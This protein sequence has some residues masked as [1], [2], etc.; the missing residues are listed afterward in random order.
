[1][2]STALCIMARSQSPENSL[3][4]FRPM[5]K[6]LKKERPNVRRKKEKLKQWHVVRENVVEAALVGT[7]YVCA[8]CSMLFEKE[9]MHVHHIARR[10]TRPDLFLEKSNLLA[11]CSHCHLKEHN[12]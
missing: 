9:M 4:T 12:Q 2:I 8:K 10:N 11:L 7:K 5:K 1:M 3:S 6:P